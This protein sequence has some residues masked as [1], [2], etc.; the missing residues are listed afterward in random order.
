MGVEMSR[1]E[2]I[3]TYALYQLGGA[4]SAVHIEEIAHECHELSASQFAWQLPKYKHFPDIKAV[5][6]ALDAV[7][8]GV[9]NKP[10]VR[11]IDD[12]SKG[13]QRYKLTQAGA[14]WIKENVSH[15]A[16]E[17]DV[18]E[19]HKAQTEIKKVLQKLKKQDRAFNRY[20]QNGEKSELSIYEFVDFLGCSLET[21]PTAVRNKF[22]DMETKAELADDAD[23]KN[24]LAVAKS[25]FP[26][27]LTVR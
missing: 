21:S 15:I 14:Q 2:D 10:L 3:A 17:L 26:H 12:R 13:G 16:T 23:I 19:S 18:H 9:K 5:Y 1:K 27:I 7:S 4:N 25:K 22:A 8:R 11:K 20:K 24:F 6:Y